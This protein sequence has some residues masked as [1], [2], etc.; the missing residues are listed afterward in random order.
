MSVFDQ[1]EEKT[2]QM[3]VEK[4]VAI[5]AR[6]SDDALMKVISVVEKI[7]TNEYWSGVIRSAREKFEAGHPGA[8]LAMRF[9]RDINPNVRNK[10]LRN[11]IVKEGLIAP[12]KRHRILK[13]EGFY[14]PSLVVISPT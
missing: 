9:L 6:G 7:T 5:A 14:P 8:K 13:K 2:I 3:A 11:F 4:M 10:V 1:I 12:N